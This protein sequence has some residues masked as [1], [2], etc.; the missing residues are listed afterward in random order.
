M[1]RVAVAKPL[2]GDDDVEA[3]VLDTRQVDE[4]Q[5]HFGSDLDVHRSQSLVA[6]LHNLDV[7]TILEAQWCQR[8]PILLQDRHDDVD[9][10]DD[11]DEGNDDGD[12]DDDNE[13]EV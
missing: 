13:V 9:D 8:L 4:E 1:I 6:R 10:D 3:V 12:E 5:V 11:A 7:D 2:S